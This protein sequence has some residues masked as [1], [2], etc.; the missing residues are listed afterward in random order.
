ME[1]GRIDKLNQMNF[2]W[3][4]WLKHNSINLL[5]GQRRI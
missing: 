2:Q 4:V 3:T 1:P 5:I